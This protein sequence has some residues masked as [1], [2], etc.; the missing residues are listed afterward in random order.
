M[1]S[2]KEIEVKLQLPSASPA[3]L[4]RVPLLRK[5]NGSTRKENQVSVYFD[6]GR[7]KLRNSGLTLRVRHVGD[8]YI[9][10]IK[11]DIGEL[12]ER[13]EWE[14][15]IRSDWPDLKQA[16]ASA[17]QPLDIKRLR[18]QLRPV[19]ETRVQR[20]TY[21]LTGKDCDIV[22]TID[23][24]EI[25]AGDSTL[26]LC[27]AELELKQGDRARLF[28]FAIAFARATS[29]ELAI[30]SK[31]QRG[32]ELLAGDGVSA[33]KGDEV[34]IAP[35][36]PAKTAFQSIASACL[37]QIVANKPAILAGDPEGIHQ[38]RVGLR[39]LRA[40]IS[41]FSAIVT[42]AKTPGIKTGLKWL[43]NELG[44]AREFE[45]F[46]T[47]VVAPLGKQHARLTGMR[48]LSHD[49]A[50]R[51]EAAIARALA[52][53]SSK[54]FREL[55]LNCAAWLEVGDWREPRNA[56]LRER[57]DKPIETV[58]RAQLKRRWKKIRKRGRQLA[59]LDPHARHKLRIQVKKLR[60]ATEFYKTVFS[61]KKREK[62][63]AAFL[64]ALKDMQDCC[65][66]LNDIFVHEKLTAG[67]AEAPQPARSSRRVFA[68]GLLIG[69]EEARFEPVLA[70]AEHAFSVF[71][72]LNPYWD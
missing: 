52:A 30:K 9:Q 37:K 55:T 29:A 10:T 12:F 68:A 63:N 43:T 19:F 66:E 26:P 5:I 71:E 58:A 42:D 20:T 2:P 24:G 18:K 64:A 45:V 36:T 65:G 41:L 51:R 47:R 49:L 32:Y 72:K 15:E 33:V 62:R 4:R 27:E 39:R 14:T 16:D 23:R 17:L 46:L 67:I 25:D 59:K 31:S 44:P 56:A 38:M 13:G 3:R 54:R 40:A 8:R 21:P 57:G 35:G 7:L 70:A 6:T 22:L 60:Y 50:E 11:S 48:S 61:G 1:S 28:E 34:E 53:V 69:H